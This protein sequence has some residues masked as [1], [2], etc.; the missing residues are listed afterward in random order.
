MLILC[1]SAKLGTR[2]VVHQLL[3]LKVTVLVIS[4][5]PACPMML[6][7]GNVAGKNGTVA[8]TPAVQK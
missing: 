4:A 5:K 8:D 6:M 7:L 3:Q 1:D 2:A